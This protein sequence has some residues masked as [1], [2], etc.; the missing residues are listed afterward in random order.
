[1]KF[2]IL[3]SSVVI[4]LMLSGLGSASVSISGYVTES[5]SG[6]DCVTIDIN[7]TATTTNASGYYTVSGMAENV[8][9]TVT[10]SKTSY[11]TNTLDVP[12]TVSDVTDA[13]LT[14]TKTTIGAFLASLVQ[15]VTALTTLFTAIM[16]VF[17]EPPLSIFVGL[18]IFIFLLAMIKQAIS[19]KQR[20]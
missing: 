5:G 14:L 7:G 3:I 13:D 4:L 2:N 12:V 6:L 11:T 20:R 16:A 1:M 8:T 10:A 17:M 18:G 19:A 15:I 9:H